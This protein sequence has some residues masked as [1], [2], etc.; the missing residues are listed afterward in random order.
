MGTNHSYIYGSRLSI[1]KACRLVGEQESIDYRYYISSLPLNA[2]LLSKVVRAHW[3]FENSAIL[4][5]IALNLVKRDSSSKFNMKARKM[6]AGWD[7]SYL[8]QL[9]FASYDTFQSAVQ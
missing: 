7:N 3:R 8:E 5:R 1:V 9:L 6:A 4:R 2:E